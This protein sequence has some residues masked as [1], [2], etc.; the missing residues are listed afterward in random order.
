MA[1]EVDEEVEEAGMVRTEVEGRD[2]DAVCFGELVRGPYT[3]AAYD[4]CCVG[5]LREGCLRR[6]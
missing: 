2:G 5:G 4:T 1:R 6:W 3:P